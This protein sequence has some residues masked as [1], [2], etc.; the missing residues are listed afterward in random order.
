MFLLSKDG[1]ASWSQSLRQ[2][3]E[4]YSER[5]DH[6]LK[7]INHPEALAELTID[8]LADDPKVSEPF[9]PIQAHNALTASSLLGILS[10]KMRLSEQRSY[11]TCKGF[12]M[13]QTIMKTICSA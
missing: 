5:R 1:E 6:F 9:L 4:L 3:R 12:R 2:K 7:F 8:P 11:K 13:K 10:A